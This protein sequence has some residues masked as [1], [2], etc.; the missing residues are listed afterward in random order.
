MID[1]TMLDPYAKLKA[2]T[3]YYPMLRSRDSAENT[4]VLL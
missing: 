2:L 1:N 3:V 4:E